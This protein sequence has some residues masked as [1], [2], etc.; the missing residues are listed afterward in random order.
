MIAFSFFFFFLFFRLIDNF[1]FSDTAM[2]SFV[3]DD[4][5]KYIAPE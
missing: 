3:E 1:N 5:G 2:N 4:V